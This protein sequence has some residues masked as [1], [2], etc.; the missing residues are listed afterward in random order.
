MWFF[1]VA[2][3]ATGSLIVYYGLKY[4]AHFF[5]SM[6]VISVL[7]ERDSKGKVMLRVGAEYVHVG[8]W[9]GNRKK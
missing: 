5:H 8:H 7:V 1:G 6:S 4:D 2:L 3:V 9:I